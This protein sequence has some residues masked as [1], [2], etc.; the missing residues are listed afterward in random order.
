MKYSQSERF[1]IT[2]F[3]PSHCHQQNERLHICED[4]FYLI[5]FPKVKLVI[6]NL[7]L[8]FSMRSSLSQPQR[9]LLMDKFRIK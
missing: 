5:P 1:E 2:N 4:E 9:E 3:S 6:S 8:K 7:A